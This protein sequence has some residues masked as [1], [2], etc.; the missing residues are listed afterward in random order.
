MGL[1]GPMGRAMVLRWPFG[2]VEVEEVL[3]DV[4]VP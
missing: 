2:V 3:C 1:R 4:D